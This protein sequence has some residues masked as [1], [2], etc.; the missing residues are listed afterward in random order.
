MQSP[1]SKTR[2]IKVPSKE[3]IEYYEALYKRNQSKFMRKSMLEIEN[4]G[5]EFEY[6]GKKYKLLGSVDANLMLVKDEEE[7]H[8]MMSS[9]IITKQILG[10]N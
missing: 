5:A 4:L 1:E 9:T 6:D 7:S 8:F 3:M 2:K 10:K